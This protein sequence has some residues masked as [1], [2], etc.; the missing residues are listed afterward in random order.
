M[1]SLRNGYVF[2][3]C[4]SVRPHN[5]PPPKIYRL[6]FI[7]LSF[8]QEFDGKTPFLKTPHR[9]SHWTWRNQPVSNLEASP[10]WVSFHSME[11]C[12]AYYHKREGMIS[13]IQL[14][15]LWATGI[16]SLGTHAQNCNSGIYVTGIISHFLAEFKSHSKK[17]KPKFDVFIYTTMIRQVL[18]SPGTNTTIILLNWHSI[19]MIPNNLSL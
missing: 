17:I 4:C 19:K 18:G 6:L 14:W 2:W 7:V 15:T 12:N 16:S 8:F 11:R 1:P 3:S 9:T 10:W 5:L 13:V